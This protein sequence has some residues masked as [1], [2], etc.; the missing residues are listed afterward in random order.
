MADPVTPPPSL[1]VGYTARRFTNVNELR[2]SVLRPEVPEEQAKLLFDYAVKYDLDLVEDAQDCSLFSRPQGEGGTQRQWWI[3]IEWSGLR[4]IL[5]KTGLWLPGRTQ[6]TEVRNEVYAYGSCYIRTAR[7]SQT[8]QEV[9]GIARYNTWYER[10]FDNTDEKQRTKAVGDWALCPEIILDE[11][12]QY[13]A[14][15]KGLGRIV[16]AHNY[17]YQT[18]TAIF[19]HERLKKN[20]ALGK[21]AD[22]NRADSSTSAQSSR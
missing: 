19:Y 13:N 10:D 3:T 5:F 11:I 9:Q 8:W 1:D 18:P 4:K 14:A 20:E 6:I 15:V 12:A 16:T 21:S 7:T 2:K 22:P 17:K